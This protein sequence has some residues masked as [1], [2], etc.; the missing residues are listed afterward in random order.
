M[1]TTPQAP[2]TPN[3]MQNAP[4]ARALNDDGRIQSGIKAERMLVVVVS[5][6][7]AKNIHTSNYAYENTEGMYKL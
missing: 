7:D 4:A 2:W 3:W 1:L 6:E 5:G